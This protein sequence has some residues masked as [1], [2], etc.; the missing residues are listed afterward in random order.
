MSLVLSYMLLLGI[1]FMTGHIVKQLQ[2]G[3]LMK[4]IEETLKHLKALEKKGVDK[5]TKKEQHEFLQKTYETSGILKAIS[6]LK[7]LF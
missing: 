3:S 4:E 1:G 6:R 5:L 7:S 2:I